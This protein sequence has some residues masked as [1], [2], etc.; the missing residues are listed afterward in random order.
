MKKLSTIFFLSLTMFE[1]FKILSNTVTV[2]LYSK[3]LFI[4]V[5]KA[6]F[7]ASLL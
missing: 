6:E 7:S 5:I 3:V 2:L 1:V 4:P